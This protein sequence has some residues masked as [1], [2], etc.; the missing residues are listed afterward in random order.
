MNA[1][2]D[3]L[4][5]LKSALRREARARRAALEPEWRAAASAAI[6]ARILALPELQPSPAEDSI[7]NPQSAIRNPT[8]SSALRAPRLLQVAVFASFGEEIDTYP[9]LG[10][11]IEL[12]GGVL[13]PRVVAAERRLEFRRVTDLAH[14]LVPAYQGIP[15]PDPAAY[16][17]TVAP[18]AMDLIVVPGLLYDRCGYRLGYGGGFYDKLL[19]QPRRCRAAGI[20]FSPLL[21]DHDLPAADFDRPVDLI[22]TESGIVECGGPARTS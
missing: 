12:A 13:L 11:L 6:C 19:A 16:P 8:P 3:N 1:M 7:R 17:E 21:T 18:E 5:Q 20:V 4:R 2:T 14:G 22:V 10:R 15:E 9:L